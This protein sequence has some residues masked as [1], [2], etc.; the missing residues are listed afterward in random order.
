MKD[1]YMEKLTAQDRLRVSQKKEWGEIVTG[2]E[3]KNKYAVYDDNGQQL[4]FAAEQKGSLLVRLFLKANRPFYL[5]ILDGN[6]SLTM[7]VKR[8]FRFMFHEATVKD[9]QGRVLG[10]I[11]KNFS[12]ISKHYTL[13]DGKNNEIYTL[14]G[15]LL[16]PWTFN[17]RKRGD[18]VGKI[19]KKWSGLLKE[20]FS[21]ADNFGIEFPANITNEVKA[22]LLGTVFLIDF[23]HFEDK[24]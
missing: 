23:V 4:Y 12:I 5:A 9:D 14:K 13:F 24:D 17:I 7:S 15:P 20:S 21:D 19:T 18:T 1:K 6:G 8:P 16:K 3:T 10:V 2:F 11:K 22:F